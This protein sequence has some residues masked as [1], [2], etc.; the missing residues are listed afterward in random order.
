[1]LGVFDEFA[2]DDPLPEKLLQDMQSVY[3]DIGDK[4]KSQAKAEKSD[5]VDDLVFEIELIRQV[6]VGVDYILELVAK[7]HGGNGEDRTAYDRIRRAVASSP[8][9]RDKADLIFEFV[10]RMGVSPGG[11]RLEEGGPEERRRRVDDAW[12]D[13]LGE[14]VERELDGIIAEERLK[15]EQTRKVMS[16]AFDGEGVPETGTLVRDCMPRLSRFAKGNAYIEQR[17]R[18]IHKLQ[19]F[20]D[21][22]KTLVR[23]YPLDEENGSK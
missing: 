9:L 2:D 18:V 11:S 5:I 8:Q 16:I 22:F 20:Y 3:L 7:A 21:K 19:A 1:M 23:S 17:H 14:Q 15:P 12:H 4:L 10:A 13:Y 6:E